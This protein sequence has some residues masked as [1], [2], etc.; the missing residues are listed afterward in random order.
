MIPDRRISRRRILSSVG[1]F[2]AATL[3]AA[4]A[5]S[6]PAGPTAAPASAA[7]KPAPGPAA[8][9]APSSAAP[10]STAPPAQSAAPTTA[11]APQATTAPVA[12]IGQLKQVPRNK[13]W[14]SVGVGGEAPQQFSDVEMQNPF[15]P[16]ISRSGYQIVMEPLF[17]Y[18]PYH[19]DKVCA[20]AG[21]TCKDGETAWI[22]TSFKFNQ[23][24]TQVMVSLRNGVR[25][26]D[27]QPF[28]A[29]DIA[30]T[31]NMLKANP[32]LSW[33]S[34]MKQWVKDVA[35]LDDHT[36]QFTLNK[37]NPRFIFSYFTFHE[38]V[39]IQIVPEHI[40]TGQDPMK[41][42]NYDLAKG[43][44]V[45]TGPYKLVHSDPQ[46]KIWDRDENWWGAKTGFA[47]LPA[48]ERLIFLPGYD[49]AKQIE[50]IIN[51]EVDCTLTVQLGNIQ[52]AIS[53][54]PKVSSWSGNKD[55]YGYVDWWPTGL[56][57]NDSKPPFNDPDIRWAI[58][59][60]INRD[61]VVQ[62][63]YHGAGEKTIFPYPDF[64]ALKPYMDGLSDIVQKYPIDSFDL[65]KTAQIMQSKGYAKDQGGFWAKDGKRLS[66]IVIT[67]AVEQDVTP[68]IVQQL[69]KGGFDASF[70]MPNNFSTLINTGDADA[71]VFGH[72][73]S[74][75][76]PYFTMRLYQSQFSAPNGQPAVRPYRWKNDKFDA[77]VDQ[78][79]ETDLTDP[80]LEQLFHQAMEIWIPELPDIPIVQFYHRNPVNTTYWTNW[81][82]E[83]NPYINSANWHRTCELLL[84]GL[85][86]ATG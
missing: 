69:R 40:F 68:V 49:E 66:I 25:W 61:Q 26:N 38:D 18:N 7:T 20:P 44:P 48:P 10:A 63:G 35:A 67:F 59:H 54:N 71:Y 37:P 32:A 2:G 36:V 15:L 56:G 5:S 41:F 13:T 64:P 3:L 82:D 73:G 83:N 62:I 28:T 79:G 52:A 39:G 78:M 77:L 50:M 65:N 27:G 51:N 30:F 24:F 81:P 14:I 46:Q 60:T 42:T 6:A 33:G 4:C 31:V 74:V 34:D 80:K 75:R 23:D 43:W 9:T 19:T 47:P 22:G 21:L 58:N 85:K 84:L 70:K 86:P 76:D 55:P 57:F 45:V 16:G 8:T 29:K 12:Q 1:I 72:G 11:P 53:R 17:Y